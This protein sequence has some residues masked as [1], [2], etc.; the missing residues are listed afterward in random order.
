ME[1]VNQVVRLRRLAEL[2]PNDAEVHYALANEL[3]LSSRH[4][5]AIEELLIVIELA[6]NHLAGRKLLDQLAR[7]QDVDASASDGTRLPAHRRYSK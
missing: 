1:N 4:V 7:G 2:A 3:A 5:E 6:P